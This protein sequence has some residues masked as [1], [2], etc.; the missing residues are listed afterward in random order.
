MTARL[1]EAIRPQARLVLVGDA[2][3]LASVEAGAVLGDIV[4]G[5]S[6]TG[7]VRRLTVTHRFGRNIRALAEAVKAGD[8]DEVLGLLAEGRGA[9]P[10]EDGTVVR[11]STGAGLDD[12]L[13]TQAV[14]LHE[15]AAA[16]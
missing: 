16:G 14:S 15:A 13:L 3:Q 10:P 1:L 12:L 11:G 9:G 6:G 2:D 7:P 5:W 4:R 8:V